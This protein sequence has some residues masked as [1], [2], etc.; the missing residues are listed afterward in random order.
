M[1]APAPEVPAPAGMSGAVWMTAAVVDRR[2]RIT[3]LHWRPPLQVLR[4]HHLD[5]IVP[6]L[7]YVTVTSPAGGVLGGDRLEI[8]VRVGPGARL[9]VDTPSA[10]RLYR[11]PT[12]GAELRTHVR[13]EAG[14]YLEYLPD[15]YIPFAGSRFTSRTTVEIADDATLLLWEIVAP[16]RAARG[17]ILRFDRFESVLEIGRPEEGILA[18]DA[19]ILDPR[20]RLEAPGL[21]G[22]FAAIGTLTVVRRGFGPDAIRGALLALDPA[23]AMAGASSLPA[24]SGAW[25]RVLAHDTQSVSD[26]LRAAFEAV[27]RDILGASSPPDRRP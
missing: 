10:T 3:D 6:D 24:G 12:A 19:V 2:T 9:H 1:A 18:V 22:G 20:E 14:A 21:L 26:A 27:R 11:T 25:L 7:A 16:G 4:A 23:R 8:G 13:V 5:P 15:P 17:E